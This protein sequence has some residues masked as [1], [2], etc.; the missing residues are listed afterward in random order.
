MTPARRSAAIAAR[1][2]SSA[3]EE[4]YQLKTLREHVLLR[5][6]TY[7][8]SITPVTRHMWVLDRA[9]GRI[10]RREATFVPALYKIFDEI[11]VNAMD[12]RQRDPAGTTRVD[13]SIDVAAGALSVRNN[14]RGLPIERYDGPGAEGMYVPEMLFGTL[15][16]GSNFD[17]SR[18]LTT[19]GR[20]GYG[21]K[22]ANIFSTEF[23][24]ESFDAASATHYRQRWCDNMET[25]HEPE[26]T[27]ASD[28]AWSAHARAAFEGP[29]DN[30]TRVSFKPDLQHFGM[31]RLDEFEDVGGGPCLLYTSPSPRD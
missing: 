9:R 22:L 28:A 1:R 20:N 8:G 18:S 17:D 2:L 14:G 25:R 27:R 13:V 12:N 24:L 31:T 26:I 10:V 4:R 21:A 6:D 30:F 11:L 29:R 5:P 3:S 19:G 7:V 23:V 15:L 16:T